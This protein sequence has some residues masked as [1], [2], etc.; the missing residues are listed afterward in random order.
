[1]KKFIFSTCIGALLALAGCQESDELVNDF[2]GK[3]VTVT[4]NIQGSPESRVVLTPGEDENQYPIVRVEWRSDSTQLETFKVYGSDFNGKVFTQTS[5]NQF[6]GETP[7][8]GS[9]YWAVYGNHGVSASSITYDFSEQDG[10]LNDDDFLMTAEGITDLTQTI[11]FKHKTAILKVT[12]ILDEQDVDAYITDFT[13]AGVHTG[14]KD[15]TTITVEKEKLDDDIYVFLPIEEAYTAGTKFDFTATVANVV[16]AGSITIPQNM[17]VEAGKFYTANVTLN[18]ADM[19]NCYLPA[20]SVFNAAVKKAIGDKQNVTSIV[21]STGSNESGG[22]RIGKSRAMVKVDG[23]ILKVYTV[24]SKFWFNA[25]CKSMFEGLE[26]ITSIDWGSSFSTGLVGD[27]SYM[28]KD[29]RNLT[30]V[31]FPESFSVFC[32]ST[33]KGMFESC[34]ALTRLELS[35]FAFSWYISDL[36]GMFKNCNKLYSISIDSEKF[37]T[38][39]VSDMSSMFEGCNALT[40]FDVEWSGNNLVD[41]SGMF[42]DCWNLTK[43]AFGSEFQP[44]AENMSNMFKG[45]IVLTYIDLRNFTVEDSTNC[46]NMFSYLCAQSDYPAQI[47]VTEELKETLLAKGNTAYG[48]TYTY[49]EFNTETPPASNE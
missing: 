28:F 23:N 38:N 19:A 9:P 26:T 22:E 16:C 7:A 24:K 10:A 34:N 8:G 31:S 36:S 43:V 18:D 15:N 47:Y 44:K 21:F 6:T 37:K 17:N 13:M 45:C 5:G 33:M 32:V 39:T 4:A 2:A 1:M 46:E 41:M 29:C 3:P 40:N 20:G 35:N 49:A 48:E 12:F 27:M 11:E 42:Q 14:V 25:D 30:S